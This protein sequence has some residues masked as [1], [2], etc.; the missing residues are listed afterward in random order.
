MRKCK[1]CKHYVN[2]RC[3]LTAAEET[4]N[5]YCDEYELPERLRSMNP[6]KYND[7]SLRAGNDLAGG[8][9][10][11]KIGKR[12]VKQ[13][14]AKYGVEFDFPCN[15]RTGEEITCWSD[16]YNRNDDTKNLKSMIRADNA[17]LF[18]ISN[19]PSNMM[20]TIRLI[21]R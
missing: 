19:I 6:H 7:R 16:C 20:Y 17:C 10:M 21:R 8:R 13:A 18:T 4:P 5:S 14:L 15:T 9:T 3:A 2:G 1:T 11:D 12:E